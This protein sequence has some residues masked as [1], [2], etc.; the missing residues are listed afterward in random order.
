M[1]ASPPPPP[2]KNMKSVIKVRED[3]SILSDESNQL[4]PRSANRHE[5][6]AS[7]SAHEASDDEQMAQTQNTDLI[8]A[9]SK[10]KIEITSKAEELRGNFWDIDENLAEF[11]KASVKSHMSNEH[12]KEA[13]LTGNPVPSNL[14][15]TPKLDTTILTTM[16][17]NTENKEG[18]RAKGRDKVLSEIADTNLN[19]MGPLGQLWETI[20]EHVLDLEEKAETQ[21]DVEGELETFTGIRDLLR[22]AVTCVGQTANKISYH[23]RTWALAALPNASYKLAVEDVKESEEKFQKE[24]SLL[25]GDAFTEARMADTK[26]IK[27]LVEH[28]NIQ[29]DLQTLAK[30]QNK[31]M[32][33]TLFQK[34]AT[35]ASGE[36]SS[37]KQQG[38]GSKRKSAGNRFKFRSR[39]DED[40][41]PNY[42]SQN[43]HQNGSRFPAKPR[44]GEAERLHISH[45]QK[46][47][48]TFPSK[49]ISGIATR[50]ENQSLSEKLES[51][52]KRPRNSEHRFRLENSSDR[53]TC[54]DKTS[55]DDFILP[56]GE[57]SNLCG[58]AENDLKGSHKTGE[59]IS[60]SIHIEHIHETEERWGSQDHYQSEKTKSD[61]TIQA[62][63]NGVP[64]ESEGTPSEG[65][66]DVQNRSEGRLLVHT[67]RRVLSEVPEIPL[68][69]KPLPVYGPGIWFGARSP[70]FHKIDESPNISL[71]EDH[72]Q[73]N[74]LPGRSPD[75]GQ[76]TG[77]DPDSKGH[78]N[79]PFAK[80]R[81]HD[82]PGQIFF[83]S[84]ACLRVS[85]NDD[86]QSPDGNLSPIREERE[87]DESVSEYLSGENS[88]SEESVSTHWETPSNIPCNIRSP[89]PTQVPSAEPDQGAEKIS[90]LRMSPGNRQG[91][92]NRVEMVDGESSS[93]QKSSNQH[94]TCSNDN[95]DRCLQNSMGCSCEGRNDYRRP[96]ESSGTT[97]SYKYIGVKSGGTSSQDYPEGS[98]RHVC[99]YENRQHHRPDLLG[100]DG[101]HKIPSPESSSQK[102][103]GVPLKEENFSDSQLDSFQGKHRSRSPIQAGTKLKRLVI[104][105][106]RFPH[107]KAKTGKPLSRLLRIKN[108]ASCQK[109][110]E[111]L[112]RPGMPRSK[113]NVPKLGKLFSLP[114]STVLPSRRRSPETSKRQSGPSDSRGPSLDNSTL[115]SIA[116]KPTSSCSPN[117]TKMEK[118]AEKPSRGK[119]PSHKKREAATRSLLG[120]RENLKSQGFS[121]RAANLIVN[122]RKYSSSVAYATSWRKWS[123]WCLERHFDPYNT[124][125]KSIT[126]FLALCYLEGYAYMSIC[127]IRS[128]ISAYHSP[129]EG[130]RVGEHPVI[131]RA[132]AGVKHL[133]PIPTQFPVIWDVDR[134]LRFLKTLGKP[135]RLSRRMLSWK[136]AMLIALTAIPR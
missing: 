48:K 85:R 136:T 122:A 35:N 93:D 4:S 88:D 90:F 17:T 34:L 77:G 117:A 132:I 71:E 6:G 61:D 100:E 104:A 21:A 128:A 31:K 67:N 94:R 73:S 62:L 54:P 7:H 83:D 55:R 64:Q 95:R 56:K 10:R 81:F 52:L 39:F 30:G 92:V 113:C 57:R 27:G 59:A 66:L 42:N 60:R 130:C 89:D 45:S 15:K 126:D 91:G 46:S 98:F 75:H 107:D 121:D 106:K 108:H 20:E 1:S 2:A 87:T 9:G 50:R 37:T 69:G 102:N 18:T 78:N 3:G 8:K 127:N 84:I 12:I 14:I 49:L 16:L 13:I 97:P 111:P 47:K 26:A 33:T 135:N 23:R 70:D 82:K 99:S 118:L 58:D 38:G 32:K 103:L 105:P 86:R 19:V 129:I 110:H 28:I 11:Y 68:G 43:Y 40:S 133:R 80:P 101:G 120:H 109:V 96:L 112:P 65:R 134:V 116:P 25:F 79:F 63:Q 41:K 22:D 131:I 72:D 125:V 29:N 36:A 44:K 51:S 123:A 124:D 115:V 74:N 53:V 76:L 5:S 114:V 119:S 24:D